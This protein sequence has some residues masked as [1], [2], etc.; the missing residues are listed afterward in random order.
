MSSG[1]TQRSLRRTAASCGIFPR[2]S[3]LFDV[4]PHNGTTTMSLKQKL[5]TLACDCSPWEVVLED[6]EVLAVHAALLPSNEV[7]FFG[8]DEH[9]RAQHD[10]GDI[11]NTRLFDVTANT[12]TDPGSPE[13]DA[14]CCGHALLANGDLLVGG[15]TES[16]RAV[17]IT[18]PHE[19]FSGA[20]DCAIFQVRT[21]RWLP[22]APMQPAPGEPSRGGGRWYP[23]LL[24]LPDGRVL[25]VGGHP[26]ARDN[27][28]DPLNDFRHGSWTPELYSPSD[29]EW[30]YVAGEQLY[31]SPP[32]GTNYLY[33][34]RMHVMPN[35]FVFLVSP[36]DGRSRFYDPSTGNFVGQDDIPPAPQLSDSPDEHQHTSVLLPLLPGDGYTARVLLLG[37]PQ[38]SRITV[39]GNDATWENAGQ[40]DWFGE[41]PVRRNGCAV[42]LPTGQVLLCGGVTGV[43]IGGGLQER[44]STAVLNGELY[45][46]GIDWAT[47]T[48]HPAREKWTTVEAARVVRNYHSVAL[49]T[50]DG[51]VWT[52]GSNKNGGQTDPDD[53][54]ATVEFRIESYKPIYDGDPGRPTIEAAPGSI[55][56]GRQFSVR[57][58]EADSIE[59]IAV[60]RCG[61]VTHA[62][63][64][65]QRYVGLPFDFVGGSTLRVEA[66]PDGNVAPPGCYML[67]LIDRRDR[68][69][70]EAAMI[71][72]GD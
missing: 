39:S 36:I 56:W 55:T 60:M 12:V 42:L 70:H 62:F 15:G 57:S 66:P 63:D 11:H 67:W 53:L 9:S 23:T 50:P 32:D 38:P 54:D 35:G 37:P 52:A 18:E 48:Y 68:P 59:R 65:D 25:A 29:D 44:D 40:R 72:I 13:A 21:Q 28:V 30:T 1:L 6:A 43:T 24:T 3:V 33:Y 49:L 69:C 10:G 5:E 51:R 27:T 22:V 61:S 26:L 64:G 20:R 45:D 47:N 46:P 19:H 14:F 71:I 17:H 58:P 2:F 34:P 7:V 8:G 31:L 16:W 4:L 41:P